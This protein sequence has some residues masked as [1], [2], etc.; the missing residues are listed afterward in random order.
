[1]KRNIFIAIVILVL[2]IVNGCSVFSTGNKASYKALESNLSLWD[3]FNMQGIVEIHYKAFSFRKNFVM[4]KDGNRFN[5]KVLNSGLMGLNPKP[6]VSISYDDSLTVDASG[7][8]GADSL[9]PSNM[10]LDD[11]QYDLSLS[12]YLLPHSEEIF[13]NRSVN[14]LGLDFAFNDKMQLASI[15]NTDENKV[16]FEYKLNGEP[17]KITLVIDNTE[18]LVIDIDNYKK[19]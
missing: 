14:K 5:F 13:M 12:K 4:H 11:I 10:L 19:R 18:F 3:N 8:A 6:L 2:V 7:F 16:L 9:I 1:M 17:Q 15:S